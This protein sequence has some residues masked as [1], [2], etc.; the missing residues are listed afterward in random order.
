MN[1]RLFMLTYLCMMRETQPHGWLQNMKY[2][3]I[4]LNSSL[5]IKGGGLNTNSTWLAAKYE[6]HVD[7]TQFQL[8]NKR[9]WIKHKLHM[10][11]CK[12]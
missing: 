9:R 6:V 4:I 8:E 1:N 12:I 2:M 10:T 5:R 11:G 7:Y 3:L